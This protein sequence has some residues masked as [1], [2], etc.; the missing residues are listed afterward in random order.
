MDAVSDILDTDK[1]VMKKA[2]SRNEAASRIR[3]T[4]DD[5]LETLSGTISDSQPAIQLGA[6]NLA[7]I[8]LKINKSTPLELIINDDPGSS[9]SLT[10]GTHNHNKSSMKPIEFTGRISIPSSTFSFKGFNGR[11]KAMVFNKPT[12]FQSKNSS[13]EIESAVI[14]VSI[15]NH[16]ATGSPAVVLEFEKRTEED[17][18]CSYWKQNNTGKYCCNNI[19][20]MKDGPS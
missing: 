14:S 16:K 13:Q 12:L 17:V 6:P 7:A 1:K 3:A 20:P 9:M 15:G 10:P 19:C 8:V 2:E 5:V 4:I 11:V 18:V